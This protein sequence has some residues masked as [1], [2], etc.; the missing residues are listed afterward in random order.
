M[1]SVNLL[2]NFTHHSSI[3][4]LYCEYNNINF[5]RKVSFSEEGRKCI[6]REKLGYYWYYES[7]PSND[8]TVPLVFIDQDEFTLLDIPAIDMSPPNTSLNICQLE[9]FIR[10]AISHY[11]SVWLRNNPSSTTLFPLH[12]DFSLD[13]NI[14]FDDDRVFVIDWEHFHDEC[15][16]LGFDVL[17]MLFELLIIKYK[18]SLP[19]NNSITT[20][21]RCISFAKHL[22]VIDPNSFNSSS[23]LSSFLDCQ[24]SMAKYWGPQYRKLPTSGFSQSQVSFINHSLSP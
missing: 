11:C 9:D 7:L 6:C 14:L 21:S 4:L 23:I 24:K 13:G 10:R 20:I 17:Y 8:F 12:G 19:D 15:A 18:H 16:P 2:R 5:F 22:G 1:T 3:S